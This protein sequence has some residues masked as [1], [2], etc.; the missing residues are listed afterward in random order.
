MSFTQNIAYAQK[1]M[2]PSKIVDSEERSGIWLLFGY[3]VKKLIDF[4]I[5][6]RDVTYQTL[7]GRKYPSGEGKTVNLFYSVLFW[8]TSNR[9]FFIFLF[10]RRLFFNV[11]H[12][13]PSTDKLL[14][15][16]YCVRAENH[17]TVKRKCTVKNKRGRDWLLQIWDTCDRCLFIFLFCRRLFFNVFQL[18]PNT[19]K[20]LGNLY[21][22]RR[23]A[24][25]HSVRFP[26]FDGDCD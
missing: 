2:L 14:E 5:S 26:R 10:C 23:C 6:R 18:P 19:A 22:N 17:A 16:E 15:L 13:P 3:T 7:P 4:P 1:T 24:P 20:S 11:F 12:L 8:D 9:C 25:N 21:V